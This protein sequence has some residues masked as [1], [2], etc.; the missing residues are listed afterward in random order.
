[1]S[2]S[3]SRSSF[4]VLTHACSDASKQSCPELPEALQSLRWYLGVLLGVVAGAAGLTG[5]ITGAALVLAIAVFPYWYVWLIL[6]LPL[7]GE[8]QY[9]QSEVTTEGTMPVS[10]VLRFVRAQVAARGHPQQREPL[11]PSNTAHDR[12]V[13]RASRSL[14]SC[15]LWRTTLCTRWGAGPPLR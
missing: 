2:R 5:A 10:R 4:D 11:P 6:G 15:G 3:S 9:K 12:R 14:C 8:G 7:E 1:M 13:C